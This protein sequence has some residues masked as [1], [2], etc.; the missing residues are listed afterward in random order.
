MKQIKVGKKYYAMNCL[1]LPI[2]VEV[3]EIDTEKQKARI[4]QGWVD[5]SQLHER[6]EDCPCIKNVIKK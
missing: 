4:K 1:C 6:Q 3:L 2:Q 5:F